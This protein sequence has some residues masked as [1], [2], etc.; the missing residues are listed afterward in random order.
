MVRRDWDT[1]SRIAPE[2]TLRGTRSVSAVGWVEKRNP[3]TIDTI[4]RS[5]V[6]GRGHVG[7]GNIHC[8]IISKHDVILVLSE[9][10]DYACKKSLTQYVKSATSELVLS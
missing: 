6:P 5:W 2:D 9:N 10:C 7:I 1:H 8:S 4:T 3:A